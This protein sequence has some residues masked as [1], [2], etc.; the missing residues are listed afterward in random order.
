MRISY[1][2]QEN[3]RGIARNRAA[4][5]LATAVQAVCLTLLTVFFVITLNLNAFVRAAGRK[6]EIYAF[7]AD[8]ATVQSLVE[9][10]EVR[11]QR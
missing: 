1:I 6:V 5:L 10:V 11:V 3:G 8:D 7:L 2:L 4:F 9:R